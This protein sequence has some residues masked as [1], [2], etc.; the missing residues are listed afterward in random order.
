MSGKETILDCLI[1][2]S[3][4]IAQKPY[5]I[6][7][8]DCNIY[9]I[10]ELC[11]YL[12]NNI[13]TINPSF[14]NMKLVSWIRSELGLDLLSDK[15][16]KLLTEGNDLKDVI[17]TVMCACDYYNEEE[18]KYI[19]GIIDEIEGLSEAMR[20]KMKADN[21]LN[22]RFYSL[23]AR[24]YE[25]ILNSEM[26]DTLTNEEYGNILHNI[27]I[28]RLHISSFSHAAQSFKEAYI[29]NNNKESLRSYLFALKMDSD[30]STF[31]S[32]AVNYTMPEEEMKKIAQEYA[33]AYE[34]SKMS[35]QYLNVMRIEKLKDQGKL[36]EYRE[37]VNRYLDRLK[38]DY[39][40]KRAIEL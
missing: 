37:S 17:V 4:K 11:Y 16:E 6:E 24:E 19:V 9:T 3:G 33:S 2:C 26:S 1:T 15:L 14:F 30:E 13:Y 34:D 8:T 12:Y 10:E 32:E 7:L 25:A 35:E 18:I 40:E 23:A 20:A 31:L 27:G 29:R 22:Y 28:V 5:H 38:K 36:T 21:Y 39:S